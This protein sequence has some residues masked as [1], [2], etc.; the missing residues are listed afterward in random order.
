MAFHRV[1]SVIRREPSP[2]EIAVAQRRRG[3]GARENSRFPVVLEEPFRFVVDSSAS[4]RRYFPRE[5]YDT[6]IVPAAR[7]VAAMPTNFI[8]KAI[9]Q[10]A[11]FVRGRAREYDFEASRGKSCRETP[12]LEPLGRNS[13]GK[14]NRFETY[15]RRESFP[16]SNPRTR[17]KLV[18]R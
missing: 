3:E 16:E 18:P 15:E 2:N 12:A 17:G 5:R 7:T 6:R 4:R 13:R 10:V 11:T 8:A 14:R 1:A 9:S